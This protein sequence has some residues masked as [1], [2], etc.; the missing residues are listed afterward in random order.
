MAKSARAT[1]LKTNRQALRSRVFAPVEDARTQRLSAKLLAL[2]D[3]PS[4]GAERMEVDKNAVTDKTAG[5][6]P[7]EAAV[8]GLSRQS[9]L[10][11]VMKAVADSKHPLSRHE[12]RRCFAH[13]EETVSKIHG[14]ERRARSEEEEGQGCINHDL[15]QTG[16]AKDQTS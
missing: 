9:F 13:D 4:T 6:R 8:K 1:R 14:E 2:A 15:H 16:K 10:C 5:D 12:P 7:T 3:S 11:V